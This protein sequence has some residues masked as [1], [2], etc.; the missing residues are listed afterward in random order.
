[1]ISRNVR[2]RLSVDGVPALNLDVDVPNK[3]TSAQAQ[4]LVGNDQTLENLGLSLMYL[5]ADA[6]IVRT[7]QNA[8]KHYYWQFKPQPGI[9]DDKLD[10][11]Y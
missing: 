4:V 10:D 3:I 2:L 6:G 7:L 11:I 5:M 8:S 9:S 1:M